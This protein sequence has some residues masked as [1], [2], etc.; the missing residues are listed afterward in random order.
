[1]IQLTT[2]SFDRTIHVKISSFGNENMRV[3]NKKRVSEKSLKSI[4]IQFFIIQ[5]N[6]VMSR[7]FECE[8]FQKK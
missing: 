3:E 5:S 1:M 8:K 7:R 4:T 2:Q 6:V